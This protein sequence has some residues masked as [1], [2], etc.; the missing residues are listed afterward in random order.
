MAGNEV[1][2]ANGQRWSAQQFVDHYFEP[3]ASGTP[4]P[5]AGRPAPVDVDRSWYM[6]EG[7][8][9]YYHPGMFPI[10]RQILDNRNLA[11]GTYDLRD[12][13][14]NRDENDPS[15]TANV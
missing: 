1:R 6:D 14:P 3:S 11:S 10:M 5:V 2:L 8:G 13:V 4:T 12:F 15:L 9:R 7:P